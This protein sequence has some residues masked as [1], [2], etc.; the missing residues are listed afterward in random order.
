[1]IFLD[2][3][4]VLCDFV[5]DAMAI[6]GR[7]YDPNKWPKGEWDVA[8]VLGISVKEFWGGIRMNGGEM[9]WAGLNPYPWAK[10]LVRELLKIDQVII[11]TAPSRAASCYSGKRT[12]LMD[13]GFGDLASMFGSEKHLLSQPGRTLIDDG[14]HNTTKW[15]EAGGRAVLVPQPWNDRQSVPAHLMVDYII[16]EVVH[17]A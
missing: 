16:R 12:W 9:F 11:A 10:D 13:H 3:D 5:T 6:H 15:E 4:G 1:M 2:M 8:K 14:V 17:G 7:K